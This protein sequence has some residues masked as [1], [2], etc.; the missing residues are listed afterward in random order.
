MT[1]ENDF[2]G[3]QGFFWW[4]GVI[5]NIDDPL[6]LGRIQVRII[7]LHTDD[8]TDLPTENLPWG[9]ILQPANGSHT[10]SLPRVGEWACG[11]FQDNENAQIPVIMG[12]F[13]GIESAQSTSIYKK[14]ATTKGVENVPKSTHFDRA[15]GE[16]ANSRLS[17]GVVANT[18][19]SFLNNDL[20][21]ACDI[22]SQI[23]LG[24]AWAK[25][26][27]SEIMQMIKKYIIDFLE[28][29]GID[30]TGLIKM[31]IQTLKYIQEKLKYIQNLLKP[32]IKWGTLTVNVIRRVK[33]IVEYIKALPAR[34]K[35]FLEGCL[36]KIVGGVEAIVKELFNTKNFKDV[37]I[38]D[39]TKEI[40]ATKKEF[41]TV[42]SQTADVAKIPKKVN[43]ALTL[44]STQSEK[45]AAQKAIVDFTKDNNV[46]AE[47]I[48]NEMLYNNPL[49][50]KPI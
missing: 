20:E 28:M 15:V 2:Y 35:K 27:N 31:A 37:M 22:R 9:Q 40:D 3:R 50:G 17:R 5:E 48:G 43:D 42:K 6:K 38:G 24:I 32:I 29:I 13:N 25:M 8:K 41:N 14:Y 45:T 1:L 44:P 19:T 23:E 16:P 34:L 36:K 21:A 4:V 39:L 47:A 49:R 46:F 7:G 33:A 11:F 12:V 30:F 26:K 18:I 10:M